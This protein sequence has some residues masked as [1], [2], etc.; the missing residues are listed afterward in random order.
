[1]PTSPRRLQRT[2]LSQ[3][4]ICFYRQSL[5]QLLDRIDS[6]ADNEHLGH[7][8]GKSVPIRLPPGKCW[9]S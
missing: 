3:S 2:T 1:M 6:G 7:E 9:S 8:L 4:A 5:H